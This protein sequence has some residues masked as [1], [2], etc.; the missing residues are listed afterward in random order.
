MVG[1]G[2][3]AGTGVVGSKG[4]GYDIIMAFCLNWEGV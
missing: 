4:G 1:S 2:G 3:G